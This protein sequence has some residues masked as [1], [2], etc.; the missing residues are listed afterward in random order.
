MDFRKY[1]ESDEYKRHFESS[2][3]V[4]QDQALVA[5]YERNYFLKLTSIA[6]KQLEKNQKEHRAKLDETLRVHESALEKLKKNSNFIESVLEKN[7][8]LTLSEQMAEKVICFNCHHHP[9][10]VHSQ[11]GNPLT[12]NCIE[13]LVGQF[14]LEKEGCRKKLEDTALYYE[15]IIDLLKTL[16]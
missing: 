6:R 14:L 7:Y 13:V 8:R 1:K 5:F 15:R 9:H 11:F 3:K 12:E 16:I 10:S 4:Q 2:Q